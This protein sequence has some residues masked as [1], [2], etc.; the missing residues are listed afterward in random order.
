V[1]SWVAEYNPTDYAPYPKVEEEKAEYHLEEENN[2]D[3]GALAV[4]YYFDFEDRR[5]QNYTA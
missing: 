5:T 1:A 3:G 4:V 2:Y